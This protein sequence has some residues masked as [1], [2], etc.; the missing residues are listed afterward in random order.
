MLELAIAVEALLVA[1]MMLV[2]FS[3]AWW[4]AVRR[5][6]LAERV[7]G[8]RAAV[9]DHLAGQD[10]GDAQRAEL[11]ALPTALRIRLLADP[12]HALRGDGRERLTALADE[13]GLVAWAERRCA[14][15]RWSRRL[16]GVRL[17]TL[18]GGQSGPN[19]ALLCDP[20]RE[21]RAAAA[22]WSAD[23]PE[24]QSIGRLLDLLGGPPARRG[25][26][27]ARGRPGGGDRARRVAPRRAGC[28]AA[29]G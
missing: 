24:P 1:A 29:R 4:R 17:L 10:V 23:H 9:R 2:L 26:A 14:S 5:R 15:R 8:G 27:P 21:V 13:L 16:R 20:N 12:A 3:A 7:A 22:A 25:R 6:R 11:R 19:A 28:A 18:V